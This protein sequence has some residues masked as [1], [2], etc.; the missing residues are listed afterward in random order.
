M[1]IRLKK[2][3]KIVSHWLK[4]NE[5]QNSLV[6]PAFGFHLIRHME[7]HLEVSITCLIISKSSSQVERK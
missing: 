1:K 5:S 3:Y 4:T 6:E 2:S 7:S